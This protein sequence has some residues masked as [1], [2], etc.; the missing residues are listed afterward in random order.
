VSD[1]AGLKPEFDA[2]FD[3]LEVG[4]VDEFDTHARPLIHP[5][6]EF[7]SGL[8]SVVGGGTYKGPDGVRA[9]FSD[10]IENTSKRRWRDRRFEYP[11]PDIVHFLAEF[12]FTGR[13]SGV[14]VA[15]ETSAVYVFR[16][17]MCVRIDSFTSHQEAREFVGG[18][19]A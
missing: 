3:A 5:D 16:E 9:W 6:C 13:T 18:I 19:H 14:P 12:E 11:R 17:A 15:S 1:L 8:G 2:A 4:D 7:H 10:L